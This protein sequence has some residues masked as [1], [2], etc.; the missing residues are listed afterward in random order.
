MNLIAVLVILV[1][2]IIILFKL[3]NKKKNNT[4]KIINITSVIGSGGH[5]SEMCQLIKSLESNKFKFHFIISK[6]DSTSEP[7]LKNKLK[8][9]NGLDKSEIYH[10][11]RS[12]EVYQSYFTS[13]ITTLYSILY[14]T[15]YTVRIIQPDVLLCNGKIY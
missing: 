6:T 13:I 8:N 11:P 1:I 14:T 3:L 9:W 15:F 5:T 10:I 4:S 12:R 2:F 7:S